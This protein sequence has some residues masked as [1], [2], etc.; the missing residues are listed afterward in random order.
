[1]EGPRGKGVFVLEMGGWGLVFPRT[2][3]APLQEEM[4][5]PRFLLTPFALSRDNDVSGEEDNLGSWVAHYS[6]PCSSQVPC[7][8]PPHALFRVTEFEF[9]TSHV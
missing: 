1:M 3:P 7:M 2:L 5:E 6:C 8:S 9:S 4:K